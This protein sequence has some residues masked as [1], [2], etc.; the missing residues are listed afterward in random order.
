[1]SSSRAKRPARAF[2]D[3]RN[4]PF[5]CDNDEYDGVPTDNE[6]SEQIS[7]VR[8]PK[9]RKR[10]T[11]STSVCGSRGDLKSNHDLLRSLSV[12][13]VKDI[14][15]AKEQE[16]AMKVRKKDEA[17]A[18]REVDIESA[19]SKKSELKINFSY[20]FDIHSGTSVTGTS[21]R[22][23]IRLESTKLE[24]EKIYISK[25]EVPQDI[26]LYLKWIN[27]TEKEKAKHS[28]SFR[29]YRKA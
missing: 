22:W 17:K 2:S 24:H 6:D 29:N 4:T 3:M 23:F 13:E 7:S 9:R 18:K 26:L 20:D 5:D 14:L 10:T 25:K 19:R 21:T 11:P 1:M 12:Q 15:Q 28:N 8:S 16:E 27:L